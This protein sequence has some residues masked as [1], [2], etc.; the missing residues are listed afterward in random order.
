MIAYILRSVNILTFDAI[1][2][3]AFILLTTDFKT[4]IA[5]F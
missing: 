3:L 5:N 4:V 1:N 2:L